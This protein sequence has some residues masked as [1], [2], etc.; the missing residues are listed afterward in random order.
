M[1][2]TDLFVSEV[3]GPQV[4]KK[5]QRIESPKTSAN[6]FQGK[7][8]S[9][10]FPK[11]RLNCSNMVYPTRTPMRMPRMQELSTRMSDS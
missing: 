4:L 2:E 6:C 11:N 5:A 8:N 3:A 1:P 9:T 10:L 7:K